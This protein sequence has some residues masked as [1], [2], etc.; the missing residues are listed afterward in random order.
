[1]N[2]SKPTPSQVATIQPRYREELVARTPEL[3][4][5]A[6]FAAEVTWFC[7]A[8]EISSTNRP[9]C[10]KTCWRKRS[11]QE[12]RTDRLALLLYHVPCGARLH[13]RGR[14]PHHLKD[15]YEG[16]IGVTEFGPHFRFYLAYSMSFR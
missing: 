7:T 11:S 2:F 12:S 14:S 16:R 8:P 10:S 15:A 1:M 5:L 4:A 13:S 6:L 9:R 3:K